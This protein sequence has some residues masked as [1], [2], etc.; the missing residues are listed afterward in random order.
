MIGAFI[1]AA[2][3]D[4]VN[5]R[6]CFPCDKDDHK[7]YKE[8]RDCFKRIYDDADFTC[9]NSFQANVQGKS[10]QFI[11]M[12]SKIFNDPVKKKAHREELLEKL[13]SLATINEAKDYI[14]LQHVELYNQALASL[15]KCRDA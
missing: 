14:N 3:S 4:L 10:E 8:I 6:K 5:N 2:D 7:H 13:C 9:S 11:Q 1:R 15:A 12:K